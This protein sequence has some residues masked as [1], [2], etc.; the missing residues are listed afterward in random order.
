MAKRILVTLMLCL[1]S[2]S[3]AIAVGGPAVS[4]SVDA[5]FERG[6]AKA[7]ADFAQ[8]LRG[9]YFH[10]YSNMPNGPDD[11][12]LARKRDLFV[13]V[14]N[15]KGIKAM[16]INSGC[17][18]VPGLFRFAEGYNS[19]ADTMLKEKFGANYMPLLNEEVDRRMKTFPQSAD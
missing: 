7:K 3:G 8:G 15:E 12:L 19:I 6:L 14:L 10:A 5:D 9:W 4:R 18:P 2:A 1:L 13:D 11:P 17:V 16:S